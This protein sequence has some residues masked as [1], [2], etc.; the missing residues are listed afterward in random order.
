MR[1]SKKDPSYEVFLQSED[2]PNGITKDDVLIPE[3]C[4]KC[5]CLSF[6]EIMIPKFQK[7]KVE[8]VK[9]YDKEASKFIEDLY[10]KYYKQNLVG[11]HKFIII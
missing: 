1:H 2:I 9:E 11:H 6:I 10:N 7:A 8:F 5:P 4:E 3:D